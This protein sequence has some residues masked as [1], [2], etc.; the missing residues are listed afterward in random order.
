M[1]SKLN[2]ELR[3]SGEHRVLNEF[4]KELIRLRKQLPSLARLSKADVEVAGFETEK[5]LFVRR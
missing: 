4:Y 1:R 5:A 2:Y 3:R